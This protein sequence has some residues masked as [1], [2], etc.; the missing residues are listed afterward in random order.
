VQRF[1]NYCVDRETEKSR[2]KKRK[3]NDDAENN[4]VVTSAGRKHTRNTRH[5]RA[6]ETYY[7]LTNHI[8]TTTMHVKGEEIFLFA[9]YLL[10]TM[11]FNRSTAD[12]GAQPLGAT[13][14]I[15]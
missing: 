13:G 15:T 9:V 7:S 1:I 14:H 12:C 4:T 6:N 5:K 2:E 8:K 10:D 11:L 3:L